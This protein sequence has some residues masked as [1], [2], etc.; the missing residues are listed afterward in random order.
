[1]AALI[2]TVH[3][4]FVP[5]HAPL[6]E[7]S[8]QPVAGVAVSRTRLNDGNAAEQRGRHV[9]PARVLRTAPL[10]VTATLRR[11]DAGANTAETAA[12]GATVSVQPAEPEHAPVQRTSLA[13]ALGVAVSASRCPA[14]H[15]V[16]QLAV[17]WSPGTSADTEPGP[18]IVR[19]SGVWLSRRTSQE[20]SCVSVQLP[21]CP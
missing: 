8:F 21:E 17:Q 16:V 4:F 10:P 9:M 11:K 6:H 7:R 2:G 1:M 18:E 20:E 5:R 13:P 3:A 14:F 19:E 12:P 15:V